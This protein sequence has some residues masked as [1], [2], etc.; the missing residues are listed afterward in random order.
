MWFYCVNKKEKAVEQIIF[1]L[2]FL[3]TSARCV[4]KAAAH[5]DVKAHRLSYNSAA[6]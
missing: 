5:A 6:S 1:P 2:D 4:K 3:R